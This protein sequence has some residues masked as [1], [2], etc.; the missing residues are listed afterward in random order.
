MLLLHVASIRYSPDGPRCRVVEPGAP[1]LGTSE[2][3]GGV[4]TVVMNLVLSLLALWR[5]PGT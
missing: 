5:Q 4:V 1:I 3:P 2:S